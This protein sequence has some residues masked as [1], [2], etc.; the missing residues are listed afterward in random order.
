MGHPLQSP[1][2]V[3]LPQRRSTRRKFANNLGSNFFEASPPTNPPIG[4]LGHLLTRQVRLLK[5][6]RLR[7]K[8]SSAKCDDN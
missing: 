8:I 5:F 6:A 7:P 2:N 1:F 3:Q 4:T